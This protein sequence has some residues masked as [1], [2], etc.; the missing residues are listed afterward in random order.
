MRIVYSFVLVQCRKWVFSVTF[1]GYNQLPSA[2]LSFKPLSVTNNRVGLRTTAGESM[3]LFIT[4]RGFK[5]VNDTFVL[6]TIQSTMW[7]FDKVRCSLC[8]H[9]AEILRTF[10]VDTR[11]FASLFYLL[12]EL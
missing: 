12:V 6:L 5:V 3:L 8:D 7:A 1:Y 4:E 10:N 9:F 11:S 2:H